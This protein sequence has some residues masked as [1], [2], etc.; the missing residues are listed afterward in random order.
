MHTKS[1]VKAMQGNSYEER[2]QALKLLS[3]E[4]R[5]NRQN[6]IEVLKICKGFY[7]IRP[8]D[9]F[10]FDNGGKG[11]RGHSLKLVNVRCMRDGRNLIE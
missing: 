3:L 5:R 2:L 9:L 10:Y 1:A 8:K 7:R 6:L 11:T 4:V